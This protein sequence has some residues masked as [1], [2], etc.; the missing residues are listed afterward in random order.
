MIVHMSN[1]VRVLREQKGWTQAQLA[2][3]AQISR[4]AISAIEQGKSSPSVDAA[5]RLARAL[6]RKV[7]EVFAATTMEDSRADRWAWPPATVPTRYWQAQIGNRVVAYP[8]EP[9]AQ[10]TLLHDGVE[11]RP[12]AR[13]QQDIHGEAQRTL[14]MACCDP[15]VS[16]LLTAYAKR[17][18]FRPIC[19]H[20]TSREALELLRRGVIHL[21][22]VHLARTD[23]A[24]GNAALA[25]ATLGPGHSVLHMAHWEAGIAVARAG[26]WSTRSVARSDLRWIGRPPGSG[27]R[28]CQDEVLGTRAAPTRTA[29]SHRAVVEA[30]R[31]GWAEAG[32]CLRLVSEEAGL[33]FVAV[34]RECYDLCLRDSDV[35]DPRVAAFID[36]VRSR[37][38]RDVIRDLPGYQLSPEM[39]ELEPV[40]S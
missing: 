20:R 22:G 1:Q 29:G 38:Y 35:P 14:V 23:D 9:T 19:L 26:K 31:G 2:E 8:V 12:G 34:R 40:A 5:I 30:L 21:A 18:G 33:A 10:G 36:T 25:G 17:S 28:G 4:T 32:V 16:L 11:T 3:R 15:A 7:E 27:A 6:G 37:Q 24:G 13:G 39:G